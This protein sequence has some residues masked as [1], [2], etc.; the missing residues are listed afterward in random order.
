MRHVAVRR[1]A[2]ILAILFIGCA[3]LFVWLTRG[4]DVAPAAAADVPAQAAA[5]PT[6]PDPGAQLYDTY[7][8][9]CHAVDTLRG[10]M[11]AERRREVEVFLEQHGRS[12]SEEDRLILDYLTAP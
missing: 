4:R 7:C 5:E 8:G 3:G 2:L 9:R 11:T 6:R 12:S 1:T 10:V